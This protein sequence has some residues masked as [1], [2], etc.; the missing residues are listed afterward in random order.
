[1]KRKVTRDLAKS[2]SLSETGL[3]W[4]YRNGVEREENF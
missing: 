4:I 2:I 1:M 3:D